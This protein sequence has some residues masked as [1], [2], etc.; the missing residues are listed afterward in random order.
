VCAELGREQNRWVV[1]DC[2][3]PC[4]QSAIWPVDEYWSWF[5]GLAQKSLSSLPF[6]RGMQDLVK[7]KEEK[8]NPS[9]SAKVDG[10]HVDICL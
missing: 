4:S 3:S 9:R 8:K 1:P 5:W 10:K 7:K 6:T 2:R